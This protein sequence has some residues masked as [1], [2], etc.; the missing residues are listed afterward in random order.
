[1]AAQQAATASSVPYGTL[2]HT[3]LPVLRSKFRD[4]IAKADTAIADVYTKWDAIDAAAVVVSAAVA[5]SRLA[6]RR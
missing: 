3:A 2:V 1:M 5:R 6:K 4:S